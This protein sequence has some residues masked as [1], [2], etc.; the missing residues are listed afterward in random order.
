MKL[1]LERDNNHRIL[2]ILN[3]SRIS[4]LQRE[5][6]APNLPTRPMGRNG[7]QVTAMGIGLMG[8]SGF[9]GPIMS[10]EDRFKFLDAAYEMGQRNW[11]S[12]LTERSA[13]TSKQ[14]TDTQRGTG[15][16][17]HVHGLGGSLG[18]VVHQ[19]PRQAREHLSG[20]EIRQCDIA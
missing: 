1:P 3:Y 9:Y 16:C 20:N 5:R 6:M 12:C 4:L 7:P 11:V 13:F 8:L 2:P 19:E 18:Q 10:D 17:R 14:R 15:H